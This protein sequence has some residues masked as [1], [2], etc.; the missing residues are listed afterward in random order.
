MRRSPRVC[1]I[2]TEIFA[3]G[4]YGGFG[5]AARTIGRELVR[6]GI[7]VY[8]VVPRRRGQRTIERLDGIKVLGFSPFRLWTAY[9]MLRRVDADIYHSC[10]VSVTSWMAARAMPDRKHM[11]TFRDPRDLYDWRLEFER[12]SLSRMQV[13]L[14]WFYEA[15]PLARLSVRRMDALY[16]ICHDLIPKVRAMYPNAVEPEFLPTPVE[17]PRTVRKASTPTVCYVARLDRRKRPERFLEL[18]RQFPQ[19]SFVCAGKSRDR[20]YEERLRRKYANLSNLEFTGFLDQFSSNR[21][22]ELLAKSWILVNAA[23]REALP[24]SFLEAAANRCAILSRVDP[25]GFATRFGYCAAADDFADG[26]R[27]LLADDRWRDS[28][29]KAADYVAS[30]FEMNRAMNQHL[31]AYRR[32]LDTPDLYRGAA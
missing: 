12:P 20:R 19:V 3:W 14:N 8:A 2:A 9:E 23:T 1:L 17:V 13:A 6:R 29:R 4:K 30:T 27:Y 32:L 15:G 26:L 7:D 21:H 18:A 10:E 22:A 11:A 5:R 31:E 16:A 24:N 28:G 25:D